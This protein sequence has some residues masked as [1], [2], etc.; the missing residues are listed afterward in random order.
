MMVGRP[1][2]PRDYSDGGLLDLN[3]LSASALETHGPLERHE[4]EQ[5]VEVRSSL[6]RFSDINEVLAYVDLP[7]ST[8]SRLRDAAV[9]L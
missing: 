8:A 5:I 9:F 2:L 3:N 4:A 7:D 1:D 6:G